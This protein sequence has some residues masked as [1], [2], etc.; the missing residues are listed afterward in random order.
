MKAA[1]NGGLN[2]SVLDGWFDEAYEFSAG[3]AIG[4]REPY[5]FY[6]D[7]SHANSI[8]ALLENEI[9]PLFYNSHSDWLRRVRQTLSQL[10][11]R[12]TV[13][14]T[15]RGYSAQYDRARY[16]DSCLLSEQGRWYGRA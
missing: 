14:R 15:M 11:P 3:W 9:A 2:L 7:A 12:V 13:S 6:D 4:D 16:L 10:S 1:V 5:S 8:Y